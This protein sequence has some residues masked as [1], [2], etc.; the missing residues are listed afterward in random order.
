MVKRALLIGI[1]YTGS[2]C[3][4][5]GCINDVIN[6]RAALEEAGYTHITVLTDDTPTKPMRVNILGELRRLLEGTTSADRL[7]VH[8]SGHG[9]QTYDWSG[10]EADRRD[11]AWCP[12][13]ASTA[14]VITDDELRGILA[15]S[16][17]PCTVVSDC[18]HSGT[19]LDLRYNYVQSARYDVVIQE[20]K[21][22]PLT[23]RSLV[24]LSGCRDPQ[25]SADTVAMNARTGAYQAQG[26]LTAT[27][28]ELLAS[29][30]TLTFQKL[31]RKLWQKLRQRGYTQVPCL[32]SSNFL[33]LTDRVQL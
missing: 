14:G 15:Q 23:A 19:M 33:N 2:P 9:T 30:P 11:E 28:L 20:D 12:L 32:S 22:Y 5:S 17:A 10:D 8:Y 25:T 27:L 7:F 4:L 1:N 3:Q 26:A 16:P 6:M 29:C 31:L 18:C 24:C 13:D 21:R